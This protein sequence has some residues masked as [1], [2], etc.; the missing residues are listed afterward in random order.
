MSK[1]ADHLVSFLEHWWKSILHL[2]LEMMRDKKSPMKKI[3][4]RSTQ[5]LCISDIEALWLISEIELGLIQKLRKSKRLLM[6]KRITLGVIHYARKIFWKTNISNPLI[7]TY[8]CVS[9]S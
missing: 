5:V 6:I 2:K 7:R 9:G 1:I 3:P 8:V 4:K